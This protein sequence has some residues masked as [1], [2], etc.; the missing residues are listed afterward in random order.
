MSVSKTSANGWGR[1]LSG[2]LNQQLVKTSDSTTVKSSWLTSGSLFSISDRV[3]I[4]GPLRIASPGVFETGLAPPS[5]VLDPV[6][7][8]QKDHARIWL[9]GDIDRPEFCTKC[10]DGLDTTCTPSVYDPRSG[11]PTLIRCCRLFVDYPEDHDGW[12]GLA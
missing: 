9:E 2:Q 7:Q 10:G 1:K 3:E 11:K 8:R 4:G 6:E 5:A 12:I